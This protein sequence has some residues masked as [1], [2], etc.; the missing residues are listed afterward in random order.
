MNRLE[1]RFGF[2]PFSVLRT[3]NKHWL[4]EKRRWEAL[5]IKGEIARE[6]TTAHSFNTKEWAADKGKTG[7]DHNT[8]LFDPF[9]CELMYRWFT[10]HENSLIIDPFAG[11]PPRGIVAG[12]MGHRYIGTDLNHKQIEANYANLDEVTDDPLDITWKHMDGLDLANV[13]DNADLVFTCPPYGDLEVYTDSD[14]DLSN[15]EYYSFMRS[16]VEILMRA[17]VTLKNNR[18]MVVTVSDFRDKKTGLYRGF[19][20]ELT[21]RLKSEGIPLY[22]EFI[23]VNSEGTLPFRITKQFSNYRKAGKMH[24]NILVFIKGDPRTFHEEFISL[25]DDEPSERTEWL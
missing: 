5:G 21:Y 22:N 23:L 14:S 10:P 7:A 2:S 9:L 4:D 25:S 11:G 17:Y 15:M 13:A 20:A 6:G 18:F 24:Q 8:S 1:K 19:P 16:L 12:M 3:M